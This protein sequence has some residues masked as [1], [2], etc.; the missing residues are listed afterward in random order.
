MGYGV[1]KYTYIFIFFPFLIQLHTL[2][3][4]KISCSP[5]LEGGKVTLLPSGGKVNHLIQYND[6]DFFSDFFPNIC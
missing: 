3:S 2:T 5:L 4:L 6:P 1:L